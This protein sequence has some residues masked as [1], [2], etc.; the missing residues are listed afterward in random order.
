MDCCS[1]YSARRKVAFMESV[2]QYFEIDLLLDVRHFSCD[3]LRATTMSVESCADRYG[4]ANCKD[5]DVYP[6]CIGERY[7]VG[8]S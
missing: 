8:V 4:K 6:F 5:K 3:K 7:Q 2:L 1:T